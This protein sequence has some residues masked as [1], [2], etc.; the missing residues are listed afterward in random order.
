MST[1]RDMVCSEVASLLDIMVV[2]SGML[3]I[4]DCVSPISAGKV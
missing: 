1:D 2:E 4:T 3:T